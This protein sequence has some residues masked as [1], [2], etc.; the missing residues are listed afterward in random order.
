MTIQVDASQV[1]LGAVLIQNNKPIAFASKALTK[2]ECQYANIEREM[3]AVIFKAERF[4]T[5]VY[6]RS[7]TIES[8]HK[9]PGIHLPEEPG[10]HTSLA[11]AHATVPPGL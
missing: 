6:G 7:L 5:Y 4:R 11:A 10:R 2:T 1:S 8:D 3:F 9:P